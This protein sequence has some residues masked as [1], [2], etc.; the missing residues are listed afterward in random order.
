VH[1]HLVYGAAPRDQATPGKS[2]L[3]PGMRRDRQ[4]VT[5]DR[6]GDHQ[7]RA[8]VLAVLRVMHWQLVD[9]IHR[10]APVLLTARHSVSTKPQ[11][12]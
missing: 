2:H 9:C 1:Q 3:R 8:S 11:L 12:N 4:P 10:P 5:A 6:S 7:V